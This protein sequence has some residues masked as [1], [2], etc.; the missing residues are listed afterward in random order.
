MILIE[1]QV[2]KIFGPN[3]PTLLESRDKLAQGQSRKRIRPIS[4]TQDWKGLKIH[5]VIQLVD[6]FYDRNNI[7]FTHTQV[8]S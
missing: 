8:F 5:L 4:S 1:I 2:H 6:T 7:T 3:V